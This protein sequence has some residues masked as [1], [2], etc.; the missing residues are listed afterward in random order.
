MIVL[1]RATVRRPVLL[2]LTRC[3]VSWRA[4]QRDR[5]RPSGQFSNRSQILRSGN[6]D[7]REG[8]PCSGAN[9]RPREEPSQGNEKYPVHKGSASRS[10]SSSLF[11]SQGCMI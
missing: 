5:K 11:R 7:A 10:E 9:V 3:A 2:L 8:E 6:C 4:K 1:G